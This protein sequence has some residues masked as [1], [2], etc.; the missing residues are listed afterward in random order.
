MLTPLEPQK[1][2]IMPIDYKKPA[3]WYCMVGNFFVTY[4]N[5]M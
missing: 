1:Y 4:N 2:I 3:M 5:I